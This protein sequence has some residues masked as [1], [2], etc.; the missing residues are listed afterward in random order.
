[1]FLF[2]LY[3]QN[4]HNAKVLLQKNYLYFTESNF[5]C[6]AKVFIIWFSP[7]IRLVKPGSQF[8]FKILYPIQLIWLV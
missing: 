6:Y 8:V 5:L 1:M 4:C 2:S 7:A 3:V